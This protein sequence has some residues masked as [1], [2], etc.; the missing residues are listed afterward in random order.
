MFTHVIASINKS[1]LSP[2]VGDKQSM[3]WLVD[4]VKWDL[5]VVALWSKTKSYSQVTIHSHRQEVR[6]AWPDNAIKQTANRFRQRNETSIKIIITI[7]QDKISISSF[8]FSS[9]RETQEYRIEKFACKAQEENGLS[10]NFNLRFHNKLELELL[11]SILKWLLMLMSNAI[12]STE[13]WF[14]AHKKSK[15][16]INNSNLMACSQVES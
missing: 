7:S 16:F 13:Q 8:S 15:H 3:E 11:C 4:D 6:Q 1:S 12:P 2:F 10:F 14:P 5:H 9:V